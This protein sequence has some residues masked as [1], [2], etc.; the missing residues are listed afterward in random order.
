MSDPK[1]IFSNRRSVRKYKQGDISKTLLEEAVWAA[2]Q[3][4]TARN[5]QPWEFVVVMQGPRLKELSMIVSPNGAFLEYASACIVIFCH[6]TK[7]YLEDGCAATTQALLA[8]SLAGLGACWI[9]GDKKEYAEKVRV[10]L[11]GAPDLKL[12][13]L[14]SVG[15][16]A[17][18]PAPQKRGLKELIHWEKF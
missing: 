16:P 2:S 15:K 7:Y 3:A 6:D 12:V 10:F 1:G 17:E 14:I 9:A 11:G 5:V 18:I 13:S 4:P 8:L